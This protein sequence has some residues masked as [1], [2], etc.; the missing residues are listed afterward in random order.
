MRK[1]TIQTIRRAVAA[2]RGGHAGASDAGMRRLWL[3]LDARTRGRCLT[4]A[5][6]AAA[7]KRADQNGDEH[8][9]GDQHE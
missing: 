7:E 5:A 3:M 9:P 4:A 8:A 6:E 2:V 1:P